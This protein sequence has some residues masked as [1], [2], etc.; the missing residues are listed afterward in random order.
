MPNDIEPLL[1]PFCVLVDSREQAPLHF[2]NI[3]DRVRNARTGEVQYRPLLVETKV[4]ALKSGDYSIE[5]LQDRVAVERK[6]LGDAY[7]T[8]GG[9][10]DRFERELE[11]LNAMEFAAVVIEAGW[12]S[13]VNYRPPGNAEMKFTPKMFHRSVIAWQQRY[14]RVHWWTCDTK[15]FAEKTTFRILQRF[16]DQLEVKP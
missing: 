11:R 6:G 2:R 16:W 14:P 10:R 4:V 12:K 5:G 1:V 9:G 3:V 8:F 7:G 15:D 13:I